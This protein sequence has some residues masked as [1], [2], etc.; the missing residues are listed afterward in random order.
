[1]KIIWRRQQQQQQSKIKFQFPYLPS[2][3]IL[4][5]IL[6]LKCS[7]IWHKQFVRLSELSDVLCY[8]NKNKFIRTIL[9]IKPLK[10]KTQMWNLDM[11]SLSYSNLSCGS[12]V[13]YWNENYRNSFY[14]LSFIFW[15]SL[16]IYPLTDNATFSV[17][18]RDQQY[19]DCRSF[20]PLTVGSKG[21]EMLMG[22]H[23][24]LL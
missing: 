6:C 21:T 16:A 4:N 14:H 11:V 8:P 13:T 24:Y 18:H 20:T 15:S 9:K 5:S 3:D 10:V 19:K 1:M 17:K 7:Y 12:P 2:C 22:T 23:K